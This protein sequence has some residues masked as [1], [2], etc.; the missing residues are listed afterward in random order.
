[1]ASSLA[2][3]QLDRPP[4]KEMEGAGDFVSILGVIARVDGRQSLAVAIQ[5]QARDRRTPDPPRPEGD[6]MARPQRRPPPGGESIARSER[7]MLALAGLQQQV[8]EPIER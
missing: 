7:E 5:D 4:A 2:E 1:L 3:S 8:V 6:E